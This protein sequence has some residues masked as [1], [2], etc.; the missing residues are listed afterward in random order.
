MKIILSF[1][2]FSGGQISDSPQATVLH[3]Y[4]SQFIE[5]GPLALLFEPMPAP[6]NT[7]A[8]DSFLL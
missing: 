7:E 2:D 5:K 3:N 8:V 6:E 1:T 4:S